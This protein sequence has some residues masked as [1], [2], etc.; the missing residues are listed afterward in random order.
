[1]LNERRSRG[2]RQNVTQV[3][4]SVDTLM[5]LGRVFFAIPMIVF[6][7]QY[8]SIGKYAGGLPP[9]APWAPGGAVGAYLVGAFLILVG[10]SIAIGFKARI[11]ATLLGIL[12]LVCAI[13]LHA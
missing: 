5:K 6:G 10:V 9:V 12:F 1:M 4:W 2:G 8:I 11:S 3:R 13:V 7:I